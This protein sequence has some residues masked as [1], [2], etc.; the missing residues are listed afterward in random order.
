MVVENYQPFNNGSGH[1]TVQIS[2]G[3]MVVANTTFPGATVAAA[4][5]NSAATTTFLSTLANSYA[6]AFDFSAPRRRHVLHL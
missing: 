4:A 2:S 3:D 6:I 5:G 1:G